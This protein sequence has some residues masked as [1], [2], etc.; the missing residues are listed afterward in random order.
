MVQG[1]EDDCVRDETTDDER[2][3]EAFN[4][5]G[6]IVDPNEVIDVNL[7]LLDFFI[8]SGLLAEGSHFEFAIIKVDEAVLI[9]L[10]ALLNLIDLNV[11]LRLST[12]LLHECLF[13]SFKVKH[14]YCIFPLI[15]FAYNDSPL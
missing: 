15:L 7:V 4:G 9:S 13:V 12:N 14:L 11:V 5:K 10:G 6:P 8:R 1:N 2:I 3:W